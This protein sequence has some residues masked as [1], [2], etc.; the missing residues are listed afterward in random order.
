M[1]TFHYLILSFLPSLF[2]GCIGDDIILDTVDAT[3]RI[4]NPIDTLEVGSQYTFEVLYTNN[5]G[6]EAE[7]A[8]DWVSLDPDR[9]SI[10]NQGMAMGLS[11]GDATLIV[12]VST[13]DPP[14]ADT[15]SVFVGDT[16]TVP[17]TSIRSGM[18]ATTSSY[19]LT[20]DFTL[21]AD[22]DDLV[23][24]FAENYETS[25]RLPGL[26]IYLTNNPTTTNGALEIGEVTIFEGA[27]SYT[28][29]DT[30]LGFYGYVLYFCKPFNVKV[31]DGKIE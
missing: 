17:L 3:L 4:V 10:S 7:A 27:H 28:I 14:V 26:Y 1:K 6:Q 2:S 19:K 16:T 15:L 24:S 8:I 20:G 25:D 21:E 11:E 22:G 9:V 12:R 5:V 23:L 31:G 18:V 13:D 29:P 30:P